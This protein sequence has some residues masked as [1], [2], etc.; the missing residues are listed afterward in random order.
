MRQRV[1]RRK[2]RP[3]YWIS[4]GAVDLSALAGDRRSVANG[5]CGAS[6]G[7]ATPA[8]V[9]TGGNPKPKPSAN[10]ARSPV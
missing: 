6:R 3:I 1:A 4:P 7:V 10:V 8:G 9:T 2:T 5:C